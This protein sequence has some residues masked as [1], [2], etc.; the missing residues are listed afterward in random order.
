VRHPEVLRMFLLSSHYRG[1]IN[2]S[3]VQL[4]QADLALTRLYTA[5]RDVSPLGREPPPAAKESVRGMARERFEAALDDDFNTP[6]ALAALQG[7]ARALNSAK[8]AA[9]AAV[10]DELDLELRAMAQELRS[11]GGVLGLL[12]VAVE[13]WFRLVTEAPLGEAESARGHTALDEGQIEQMIAAR[14][15]ARKARDFAAADR[16]RDELARAGVVLEDKPGSATSWK[17]A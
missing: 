15:A 11:M 1:P 14:Q 4:E 16:I 10:G 8:S 3:Q 9:T 5:L 7:L 12:N 6:D 13:H 17:R 2:Y